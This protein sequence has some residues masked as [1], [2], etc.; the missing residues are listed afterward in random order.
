MASTAPTTTP[1]HGATAAATT[2]QPVVKD[3]AVPAVAASTVMEETGATDN[4]APKRSL[5]VAWLYMFDWYPSH[6]SKEE[7]RFM[8]K[9]DA[10]LLTFCSL[11]FFLKW[12]DSSNINSA[13]VS[14]MKEELKLYGNEYSMFQTFYNIGYIICQVPAMLLLSRPK[15]SRYF[16]PTMEVLWSILTFAQCKLQN[17]SQIYGTRFLLGVLETPVASGSLFIMSSWYKPEELFKRAGLWYVSN[18][19]GV[20]FGNYLQAAAYSNLNGVHGMAGWRWL[21]IIDGCI[22]LPISI[23]GYFIFPG[24]PSSGKPWWLTQAEYELGQRRMRDVGVEE[25]KKIT[26]RMLRRLFCHWHWYVGV[27]AYVLFLSGAYPHGQMNLWLKWQAD[28][29]GTYTV[30]QINT[31]PTGAQGVSVVAAILATSLCMVY[32]TWI[33]FQI[34]MAIVMFANICLMVWFIPHG[35]HFASYYLFGVSAAVT[36]IL[37]LEFAISSFYPLVAFPVVE[38]PQW[39]KGYIVN[40]FFILGCW[41]SLTLGFWLYNKQEKQKRQREMEEMIDEEKLKGEDA[42]HWTPAFPAAYVPMSDASAQLTVEPERSP[43]ARGSRNKTRG[44]C[45]RHHLRLFQTLQR[46]IPLSRSFNMPSL[47]GFS[48]NPLRTRSDLIRATIALLRPLLPHFSPSKAR[49]KLPVSTG[50]HFDETAAQLEGFARPLWAVGALLLGAEST[51]DPEL[52]ASVDEVVQPWIDGFIAGTDPEHPEYWGAI[53]EMDQR[54]VEAEIISFALLVA[55]KR[56]YDPLSEAAKRNV[57]EWLRGLRGKDMPQNN[58]RWFRVFGNLA[59]TKVCG[60]PYEEVQEEIESDLALLDSFY[61]TDGWSADGPW[62]TAEQAQEWEEWEE[63]KYNRDSVGTGRQAD[64]YSGS[65]AIQF[66]QLLYSRFAADVDPERAKVYRQRA[67]DFGS[68][69]WRYFDADGS[70][71]PFGRSLTYR[72]ACGGYFATLAFAQVSYDDLPS[73]LNSP[74]AVKGF[75]LRHLRWWAKNSEDIFYPDGTLNIGWLYPNMYMSEDYNS[76][77]S[78]YWCLKTLVAVGLAEDD[79]FWTAEEAPFPE[80]PAS[81]SVAVAAGP[82]Q[83][84]CNRPEGN[85]HFLL[86]PGQFVGWPMKATQAKYSKFA[87]SSAFGFSVP[88]GPLIQ[89]L[90]PDS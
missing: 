29:W 16:L 34:V 85:H 28:K 46:T 48:D 4:E 9:L 3:A 12:L 81:D 69:F 68:T 71:V 57:A 64:Y 41:A 47:P 19:I 6:M 35:L 25:P 5:W 49:I 61:R 22:S 10:F 52:R 38:A 67:R 76:P 37:T 65:F 78:P 72:F 80:I 45:T 43:R 1:Q 51:S 86:S 20:M 50:T 44:R 31:I 8:R 66:S 15:Y 55:P 53:G 83:I 59:L 75:L 62:Q 70:A 14:G 39:K 74:G 2:E 7:K 60:A 90:A 77:Q 73:P 32:P 11:A 33:I 18:N 30:P 26:T 24:M 54:M 36:P 13:Y 88:T 82:E 63:R 40:F 89:Q 17:A 56:I 42:K 79:A 21:F 23:M 84:L 87:Y 27:L 58:W